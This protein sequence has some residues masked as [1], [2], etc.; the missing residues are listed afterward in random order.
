I[1]Q[2]GIVI[3]TLQCLQGIKHLVHRA[4]V[5]CIAEV[6]TGLI[7]L[8]G[9]LDLVHGLVDALVEALLPEGIA[10]PYPAHLYSDK[11]EQH[12]TGSSEDDI[13]S[14]E[15]HKHAKVLLLRLTRSWA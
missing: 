9:L 1:H 13:N 7:H 6:I 15:M 8:Q 3:K 10:L 4:G 12:E 5:A 11:T 2:P 14:A